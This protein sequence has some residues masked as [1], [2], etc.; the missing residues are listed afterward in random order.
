[1]GNWIIIFF[2]KKKKKSLESYLKSKAQLLHAL[3][4]YFSD[5]STYQNHFKAMK[6]V[7]GRRPDKALSVGPLVCLPPLVRLGGCGNNKEMVALLVD[8][9]VNWLLNR[10][11]SSTQQ[12]STT[13]LFK[14]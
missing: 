3:L 13:L 4:K 7:N 14:T 5:Q 2:L 9:L 8:W 6:F 1:M 10:L 11:S 12:S